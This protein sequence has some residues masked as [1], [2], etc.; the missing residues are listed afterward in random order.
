MRPTLTDS[1]HRCSSYPTERG[2]DPAL[3]GVELALERSGVRRVDG[4]KV[5][6]TQIQ[7]E[8]TKRI[9]TLEKELGAAREEMERTFQ[10]RWAKGKVQ[11]E[12]S[13]LAEQRKLRSSLR[14][15]VLDS[16]FLAILTAPVIYSGVVPF[17]L[18]DLFLAVYQAICFPVY[19][20]PKAKRSDYLIFDRARLQYLNLVE[21]INCGYCSYGNGVLAW[22][23]EISARTEQHWCPIKHARRLRELHSRYGHFIDYGDASQYCTQ[24][25]AVR[26]DFVDIRTLTQPNSAAKG[27]PP[28]KDR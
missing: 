2:R 20:I 4:R 9:Q 17:L 26:N 21:R 12:E 1:G 16:R 11:F 10:F 14:R 3:G 22:G 18:L 5:L 23:R 7:D 28:G 8:L 19:G 15:Y 6:V 27:T 25:D 24:I 13:V